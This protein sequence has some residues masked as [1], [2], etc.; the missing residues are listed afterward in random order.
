MCLKCYKYS[1]NI[2]CSKINSYLPLEVDLHGY[3]LTLLGRF[4]RLMVLI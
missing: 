1:K 4:N 2:I 3:R